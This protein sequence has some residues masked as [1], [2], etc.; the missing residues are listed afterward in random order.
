MTKQEKRKKRA[1][2]RGSSRFS[3]FISCLVCRA[4]TNSEQELHP[5]LHD[6]LVIP[7][8][9]CRWVLVAVEDERVHRVSLGVGRHNS[10][11]SS[12]VLRIEEIF[13]L[14]EQLAPHRVAEGNEP[15]VAEIEV[16]NSAKPA[17]IAF[18]IQRTIV[19][20]AILVQVQVRSDV[21]WKTAVGL[22]NDPCLLYTSD[23]ADD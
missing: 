15:R 14:E 10:V 20:D 19:V 16:E 6:A 12:D 4:P 3:R 1:Q 9:P 8:L 2:P 7:G 21:E 17:R 18:D 23:A 11:D 13:G 22:Q 5:Q